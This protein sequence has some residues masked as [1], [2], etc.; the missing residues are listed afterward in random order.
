MP[1]S[2]PMGT[3]PSGAESLPLKLKDE[4]VGGSA[5]A[6]K[7]S[8]PFEHALPLKPADTGVTGSAG[9]S[10]VQSPFENSLKTPKG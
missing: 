4:S 6:S 3:P 8:T 10:K 5:A 7:I 9:A 2:S 1:I